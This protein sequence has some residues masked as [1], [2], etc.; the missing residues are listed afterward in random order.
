MPVLWDFLPHGPSS[1]GWLV[2]EKS[3][4]LPEPAEEVM[5][6]WGHVMSGAVHW[7]MEPKHPQSGDLWIITPHTQYVWIGKWI[8]FR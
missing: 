1:S 3:M 2:L 8:K 7:G 6:Y 5:R 4:R